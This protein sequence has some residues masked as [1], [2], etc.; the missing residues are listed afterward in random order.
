MLPNLVPEGLGVDYLSEVAY[1]LQADRTGQVT[2]QGLE[3]LL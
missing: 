1:S 2:F 3:H